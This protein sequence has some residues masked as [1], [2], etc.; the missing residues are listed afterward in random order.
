M[1]EISV[2]HLSRGVLTY[3]IVIA[4][5]YMGTKVHVSWFDLSDLLTKKKFFLRC[6]FCFLLSIIVLLMVVISELA[7]GQNALIY[8]SA[9]N[10]GLILAGFYRIL[11]VS[12]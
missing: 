6:L 2:Q 8:S 5:L 1:L 10:I 12:M 9:I 3:A 7:K 4:I 11:V